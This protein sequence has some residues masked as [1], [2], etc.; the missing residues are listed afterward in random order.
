MAKANWRNQR[1]EKS[2]FLTILTYA[3][4]IATEL[5]AIPDRD[6]RWDFPC[7]LAANLCESF[8]YEGF[9]DS[10]VDIGCF[11]SLHELEPEA[12]P[13]CSSNCFWRL[14]GLTH[15]PH[16]IVTHMIRALAA[17]TRTLG[18]GGPKTD[19]R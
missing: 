15:A 5:H 11:R 6:P 1:F 17:S 9:V 19:A 18:G 12:L 13:T 7:C 3:N 8:G 14:S 2:G 4:S 16:G 10:V